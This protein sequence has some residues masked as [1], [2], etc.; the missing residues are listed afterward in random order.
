MDFWQI[1]M[2]PFSWLLKQFC[3]IF[4]SYAVALFVFA[5][6]VKIILA[7]FQFKGKKSMIK[8]NLV[9]GQLREIQKR[10]GND[11][12]RYNREVQEFY[13]KNNI[14]PMSGC[15]WSMLPLIILMPL[16]AIIRR[17]MKYLMGLTETATT[18]VADA[19]GWTSAAVSK[20]AEFTATGYNELYLAS[21]INKDNL[22]TASAAAGATS[23][24]VINFNFLGLDLSQIPN[25][26][27]WE[28]GISWQSIG[29]FLLPIIS[30]ALSYVSSKVTT[31]TNAMNKETEEAQ[32][33]TNRSMFI[34]MPLVSLWIGFTLPAGLCIYWIANSLLGMIQEL[35][36]ARLLRKDYEA[37]REE[38]ARQAQIAKE[39]EKERRRIA[40]EKKA[41][42]IA[43][44]KGKK[45]VQPQAKTKGVDLSA[46]R[47]GIRTYA[48]GRAY[49]PNRYPITPYND[50]DAKYKPKEEELE[51]LTDEEK[52]ILTENGVPIPEMPADEPE[53]ET[54]GEAAET[55]PVE[56]AEAPAEEAT[57]IE[58]SAELSA[59]DAA[60]AEA[61][62]EP[63]ADE[64]DYEAPYEEE[65]PKE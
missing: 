28:G 43:A 1:V 44:G 5:L 34:M 29:L 19:L 49:D 42:A 13:T 38:A 63:S 9:S 40:A 18:A 50:P 15:G 41:A 12:E 45:K 65:E 26:K 53:T 61:P 46:S 35:I 17:P 60:P 21:M 22:A 39:E 6:V 7:P 4:N 64:G 14:N 36:F 52:A 11:K 47:E 59:E 8:M 33:A 37:A 16:Y 57:P 62:A 48:R 3:I 55:A 25:W 32:A 31:K 20:G 30:A 54:A 27:F 24:F 58:A 23:L 51:P 2:T 10:C 56:P